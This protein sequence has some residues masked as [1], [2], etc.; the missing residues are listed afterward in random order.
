[1]IFVLI[2]WVICSGVLF[3]YYLHMFQLNSYKTAEHLKWVKIN[4]LK[5]IA[6]R[7]GFTVLTVP[8]AVF[9]GIF[10]GA[11]AILIYLLTAWLNRPK[12]AKKPLVYT[13]R[14]IRMLVNYGLI[15]STLFIGFLFSENIVLISVSAAVYTVLSPFIIL[16]C[17]IINKPIEISINNRYI[18]EAKKIIASMPNLTVIGITGSYGKTSVKYFLYKLLSAKYNVL[19]TPENFNTTLGVVRTI[20]E[21]LRAVHEIFICEMGAKNVGDIKEICNIVHPKHGIITAIGPQ[22]L[23]SFKSVENIIKTKFELIDALPPDGTAFLN[24]DNEYIREHNRHAKNVI[25]YGLENGV[26][27]GE[28]IAVSSK[29]SSFIL[30]TPENEAAPLNTILIGEHNALNI[31]GAAAAALSF[32]LSL[33]ELFVQVK[34]IEPVPHR[35][36]LIQG[37]NALIIDDAYNSNPS[38]AAAALRVLSAFDGCKILITPGMV[39]LGEKEDEYNRIFGT[40][41][42]DICDFVILVGAKQTKSIFEGL[43]SK[44]YEKVY[45]ADNIN[46]ALSK[47]GEISAVNKVVLLENDLPDNY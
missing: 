43:K 47:A 32:G 38:G 40:Q 3:L 12:K 41:A 42:A 46:G 18:N 5:N 34:K 45:I 37:N 2:S 30:K 17:N 20:R 6:L 15:T 24:Y 22:H 13:K 25:S 26:Y 4:F 28:N 27:K 9:F 7:A 8:F 35:L 16:L 39:E 11:S 33:K 1:M 36:Q 14:I 10:G 44:G 31:V 21:N 23:E 29:G 19:M